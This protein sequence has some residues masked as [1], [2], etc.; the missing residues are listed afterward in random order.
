MIPHRVVCALV[1]ASLFAAWPRVDALNNP[2][3]GVRVF[4][5]R[6]I[7]E[8]HTLAIDDVAKS[9][10]YI[11][12]KSL[13]HENTARCSSKAPMP[14]L[15]AVP[16]VAAIDAVTGP[17][18]RPTMTHVARFFGDGLPTALLLLWLWRRLRVHV[19][20]THDADV[21]AVSFAFG[22]GVLAS[23][24]VFSGHAIAGVASALCA[25]QLLDVKR[26][27]PWA[28]G[29]VAGLAVGCEYHAVF[30]LAPTLL[31]LLWRVRVA[32][33]TLMLVLGGIVS[34]LPTLVVHAVA[35]G[36]P[37]STGYGH[38]ENPAFAA[39]VTGFFGFRIPADA[40]VLWLSLL[41]PDVGLFFSPWLLFAFA[42]S[43][44]RRLALCVSVLFVLFFALS[45]GW[46]GGWS[47][48]P[49][50][51]LPWVGMLAVAVFAAM[52][53][54]R[55]RM[56]GVFWIAVVIGICH[57]GVAGAL[58]PHL[59]DAM[60]N[61]VYRFVWPLVASGTPTRGLFGQ[62]ALQAIVVLLPLL[63]IGTRRHG[64]LAV[65]AALCV[66]FAGVA[67]QHV[68]PDAATAAECRRLMAMP[69]RSN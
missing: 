20:R 30:A 49:R 18:S 6:A 59:S 67:T 31:L 37:W 39:L 54:L 47:V 57:S 60:H 28:V 43:P 52:P 26:S 36:A 25:S 1:F 32:R 46:R 38:L 2:N 24:N 66:A 16:A 69:M 23:M 29:A 19:D 8:Q 10:G 5:V 3:E 33:F 53:A 34:L 9:W 41:S 55:V 44:L 50:Y 42:S 40:S 62:P 65:V 64:A 45:P 56:R 11:N 13:C 7:V 12:D 14:M 51:A 15:L 27:P 21:V 63:A 17:L 22:T 68:A 48:G 61:P 4:S 35:Y 58:Y